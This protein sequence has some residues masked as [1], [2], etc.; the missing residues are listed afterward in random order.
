MTKTTV[1]YNTNNSVIYVIRC[2][3][4]SCLYVYTGSTANFTQRKA[5]HK[6]ICNSENS[7]AYNSLVY[8]TIRDNGGWDNWTIAIIEIFPCESKQHLCVREQYHIEQQDNKVNSNRAFMT[9]D[10]KLNRHKLYYDTHK[11]Q[12]NKRSTAYRE[13][14]KDIMKEYDRKKYQNSWK[15]ISRVFRHILIGEITK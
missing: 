1:N 5:V 12:E 14:N 10:E 8:K 13:A 4:S 11:E 2:K 7:K 9:D 3:D 15:T 6:N